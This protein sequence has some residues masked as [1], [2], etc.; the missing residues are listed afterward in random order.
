MKKLGDPERKVA[1]NAG[2]LLS[3]LLTAHP[4]M[5]AGVVD[6]L[7]IFVFH[8]HIGLQ[9]LISTY[10]EAGKDA[11]SLKYS[12]DKWKNISEKPKSKIPYLKLLP[13]LS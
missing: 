2:Y 1:S 6:E 3:C 10:D 13:I 4:N 5:K 11:K 7:D 9:V 8:P 12:K